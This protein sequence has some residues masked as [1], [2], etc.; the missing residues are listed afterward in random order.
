MA[1]DRQK[2]YYDGK[3]H[4]FIKTD[5]G[6]DGFVQFSAND[7][8]GFKS[9]NQVEQVCFDEERGAKEPQAFRVRKL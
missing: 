8:E 9:L 4:D 6:P 5:Q 2:W 1:E 3:G 7:E